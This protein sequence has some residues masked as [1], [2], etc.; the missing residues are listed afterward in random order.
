[1]N[2]LGIA[3]YQT[4][5]IFD[6]LCAMSNRYLCRLEALFHILTISAHKPCPSILWSISWI[7]GHALSFKHPSQTITKLLVYDASISPSA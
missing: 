3:S 1:M 6:P 5:S 7:S 4:T 2:Y